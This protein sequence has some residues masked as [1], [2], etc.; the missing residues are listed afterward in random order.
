MFEKY[1]GYLNFVPVEFHLVGTK[2]TRVAWVAS[3]LTEVIISEPWDPALQ[4]ASCSAGSLLEI[5]PSAPPCT[6]A[7]MQMC[8]LLDNTL[9]IFLYNKKCI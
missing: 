5:S 6:C 8:S 3:L 7:C 4:W 2:C 1:C 9:Y